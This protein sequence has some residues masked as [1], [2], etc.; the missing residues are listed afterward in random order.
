M[1]SNA[2]PAVLRLFRCYPVRLGFDT[3]LRDVLVPDLLGIDA[4]R[5]VIVG[6]HGPNELG[7][8][9]VASV[10]DSADAMLE[11]MG[12]ELDESRFHAEHLDDTRDRTLEVVPLR[13]QLR[14]PADQSAAILRL[15]HGRVADGGLE[16]Y[17][18]AA[19]LG[20]ESDHERLG[21]TAFYLGTTEPVD[22]VTL[23]VWP[24]WSSIATATGADIHRPIATRHGDQI[25]EFKAE[26]LE[27]VPLVARKPDRDS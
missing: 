16:R 3:V 26:H 27:V 5:D 1:P 6:R 17:V 14:W 9:V 13:V 8:R 11:A 15:S 25:V 21:S 12:P 20:A 18:E 4:V 7:E 2:P 10:W 19:R 24:S 23:S 22:F